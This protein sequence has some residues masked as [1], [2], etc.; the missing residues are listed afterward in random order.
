[1]ISGLSLRQARLAVLAAA[2][3]AATSATAQD[4]ATI[5]SQQASSPETAWTANIAAPA[6]RGA[7]ARNLL[8]L[9]VSDQPRCPP[10]Q[11]PEAKPLPA[12]GEALPATPAPVNCVV[13]VVQPQS[14]LSPTQGQTSRTGVPLTAGAG[15]RAGT[16]LAVGPTSHAGASL[17]DGAT[18]RTGAPLTVSPVPGSPE[19]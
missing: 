17:A 11:V 16:S 15:G 7:I 5:T 4:L 3:L 18:S 13:P 9:S 10:G 1:M 19:K 14:D 8:D 6:M 2:C 12:V